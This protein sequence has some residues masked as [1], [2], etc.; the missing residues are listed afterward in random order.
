METVTKEEFLLGKIKYSRLI[1]Q[2]A[3]FVHPTDTIYG[4]GCDATK[5]SAVQ[6]IREIK[7]RTAMPFSV[8]APSKRWVFEN[9][10]VTLDGEKWL[11]R[12]PGPYTL[13][14]RLKRTSAVAQGVN[15]NSGTL[16]IRIPRHWMSEVVAE[17][18]VPV[19]STSANLTGEPYMTSL[20]DLDGRV[21]Q[22]VDFIIYE[23]DKRGRPSTVV[24][25]FEKEVEVVER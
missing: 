22:K 6:R 21:K 14:F 19:V 10:D 25:L 17:L 8:I 16:G 7:Q 11:D 23:G 15:Q 13:I 5:E 3:V 9:C 20:D 4:I 1:S 2:G 18:G 24:K 12:L